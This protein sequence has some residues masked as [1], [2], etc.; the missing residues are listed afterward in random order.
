MS[1]VTQAR[2]RV[3]S[4]QDLVAGSGVAAL[5]EGVQV[6]IFYLPALDPQIYAIGNFDPFSQANV[7]AR[8]LVGDV[9]GVPVVA[10]PV[11]KQHFEL[12]TGRCLED[13][14]VMVPRFSLS[15]SG[16]DVWLD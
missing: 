3:C 7:L 13:Q 2:V 8:G 15:L 16:A 6:A 9:G 10:S 14:T 1:T 12:A 4:R 5:V 11:Y